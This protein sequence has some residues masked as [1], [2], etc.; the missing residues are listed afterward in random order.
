MMNE[1]E[2]EEEKKRQKTFPN[3]QCSTNGM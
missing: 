2:E 1:Q 3:S